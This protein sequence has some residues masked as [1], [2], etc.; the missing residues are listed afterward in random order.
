MLIAENNPSNATVIGNADSFFVL[1][2]KRLSEQFYKKA[3]SLEPDDPTW[4][5][6]LGHLY[7]LR[8]RGRGADSAKYAKLALSE[9]LASETI[10]TATTEFGETGKS[11]DA[12]AAEAFSRLNA[13]PG[14]AKAAVAADRQPD[15]VPDGRKED[16]HDG[17]LVG[18]KVHR[19]AAPDTVARGCRSPSPTASPPTET[20]PLAPRWPPAAM[21]EIAT[22]QW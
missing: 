15:G 6:K 7:S 1:N 12:I 21:A 8:S 20:T 11:E 10:R 16:G 2:D 19:D 3:Q 5:Q 18:V 14:L 17:R 4:S 13:L 9:L 22:S